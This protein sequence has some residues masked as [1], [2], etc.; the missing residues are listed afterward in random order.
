MLNSGQ[1]CAHVSTVFLFYLK[2]KIKFKLMFQSFRELPIGSI[3][4]LATRFRK[5]KKGW[6]EK[7]GGGG[8]K[9]EEK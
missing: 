8:K 3:I 9:E 2:K 4:S 5:G 7:W 1:K 6:R